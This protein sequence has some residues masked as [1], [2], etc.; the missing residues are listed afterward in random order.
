MDAFNGYSKPTSDL[1][2][3]SQQ[4]VP[5]QQL[6]N[7]N[8]TY[9]Q[10]QQPQSQSM[11]NT[12]SSSFSFENFHLDPQDFQNFLLINPPLTEYSNHYYMNL[13]SSSMPPA[14]PASSN[15]ITG[16]ASGQASNTKQQNTA[17][18]Q[19]ATAN[20]PDIST[21]NILSQLSAPQQPISPPVSSNDQ[22]LSQVNFNPVLNATSSDY[23]S[24]PDYNNIQ[25]PLDA[26]N[27]LQNL[28]GHANPRSNFT[29][30]FR[31]DDHSLLPSRRLSISNGQI[32]QIS[33][34]V[35]S[36]MKSQN[37]N[38]TPNSSDSTNY[39]SFLNTDDSI[40]PASKADG[41]LGQ[42]LPS[43]A[44]SQHSKQT[45]TFEVDNNG[46]PKHALLYNNEVIFN[47]HG[48]IPGTNA[49]KRAKILER[50]RIAASKCRAKKKNLQKKLQHDVDILTDEKSNLKEMLITLRGRI[51][52]YCKIHNIDPND[53]M[54]E[55]NT[56]GP[57]IEDKDVGT[58]G[59]QHPA[60]SKEVK[61]SSFMDEDE[62]SKKLAGFI[63]NGII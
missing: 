49:W 33:M 32:G 4:Q 25:Q 62:I 23:M 47:P 44:N 63:I 15:T 3:A 19:P 28:P 29:D 1:H 10:P 60:T 31:L 55:T 41:L 17:Y 46:V 8:T 12:G 38:E 51:I 9:V 40:N 22:L 24:I 61:K 36:Q 18:H 26:S 43:V 6:P 34:M 42:R 21:D 5:Q 58:R 16:T 37:D 52:R 53:F 35:H 2:T 13:Q 27:K 56:T 39:G 59:I 48:P 50:N 7:Q 11:S 45:N 14:P 30:D 20:M 54:N 57:N